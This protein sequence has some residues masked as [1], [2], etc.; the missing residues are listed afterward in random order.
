ME[1]ETSRPD[2]PRLPQLAGREGADIAASVDA[3][4][5]SGYILNCHVPSD[6]P[7]FCWGV[8]GVKD[9]RGLRCQAWPFF[10]FT[11]SLIENAPHRFAKY[12]EHAT[13][14]NRAKR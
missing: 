4:N 12:L 1:L 3:A 14:S 2:R 13:E 9:Y 7:T 5:F 11:V 10:F 8:E 6:A